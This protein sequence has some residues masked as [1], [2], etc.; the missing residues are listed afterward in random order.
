MTAMYLAWLSACVFALALL[1]GAYDVAKHERL[2]E[3]TKVKLL[4]DR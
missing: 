1:V 2:K 4:E 3:Q